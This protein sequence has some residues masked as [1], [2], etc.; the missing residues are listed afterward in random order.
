MFAVTV[1]DHSDQVE[2]RCKVIYRTPKHAHFD[3]A[4]IKPFHETDHAKLLGDTDHAKSKR[5]SVQFGTAEEG[6]TDLFI[7]KL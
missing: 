4:L 7:C 1:C 5:L 3:L 2:R 6:K